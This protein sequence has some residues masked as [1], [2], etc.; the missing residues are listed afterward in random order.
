[1]TKII[2]QVEKLLA[3]VASVSVSGRDAIREMGRA[4]VLRRA[5]PVRTK[6]THARHARKR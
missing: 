1:M 3:K 2:A 4:W 6:S 5:I